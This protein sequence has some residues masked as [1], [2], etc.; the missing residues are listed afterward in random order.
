MVGAGWADKI[1]VLPLA[2][3]V[4]RSQHVCTIAISLRV[5]SSLT[6]D[7][8]IGVLWGAGARLTHGRGCSLFPCASTFLSYGLRLSGVYGSTILCGPA[9][10]RRLPANGCCSTGAA[11]APQAPSATMKLDRCMMALHLVSTAELQTEVG[12]CCYLIA[13]PAIVYLPMTDDLQVHPV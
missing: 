11:S 12:N 2:L 3:P 4:A 7:I 9:W 8:M 5:V 13:S 1:W 6:R 10:C